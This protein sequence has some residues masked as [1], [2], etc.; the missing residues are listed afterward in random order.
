MS[1]A[2]GTRLGPYEIVAPLGEGGMGEVYKARDTRLGRTVAIKVLPDGD[3]ELNA[4]S[5]TERR[6]RVEREARFLSA[7]NH[8]HICVFHDVGSANGFDYLVMECLEGHTLAD[9][10]TRKGRL[11]VDEALDIAVQI[12]EALAAAH[13]QGIV[14]GD[15]KPENVMLTK[16]GAKVLDFG[17]ARLSEPPKPPA[18]TAPVLGTVTGTLPY[19]APE[20]LQ[21]AQVDARTDLFAFGAV[22]YE[23]LTGTRV[24]EGATPATIIA[25]ILEHEPRT[26]SAVVPSIPPA[27]DRLVTRCLAKNPDARWQTATDLAA[28]LR[29]LRDT[30]GGAGLVTTA[31]PGHRRAW[32]MVI[33]VAGALVMAAAGAG[34]MWLL[35]PPAAGAFLARPSLDVGPADQLSAGGVST[36]WLPTPGGSRTAIAW[37]PDGQALVFVGRRGGVQQ[38]YVRR[39]DA[40][41]ARALA[42]TEGAQAPAV[43]PDGL[44]VAFW[45]RRAIWKVPLGGG[46]AMMIAPD[47]NWPPRGQAWDDRGRLY[48]ARG[49]EGVIW[50]VPPDGGAP[51]AVATGGQSEVKHSLPW[52]LPGGQAL[53]YTVRTRQYSWGDEEVVA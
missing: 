44:W 5:R 50:Q 14:H 20:Q 45:A 52:P 6:H 4:A 8:P 23:M 9:R 31:Q 27:V 40:P 1:L 21:G 51:S 12:A 33:A 28:E 49:A 19:V 47:V 39:L 24:F 37:T 16:T 41:E 13:R 10:L 38:L 11:P 36:I 22:L 35:R 43:S 7:L 48:F 15:L 26:A 3:S 34:V 46:P 30:H 18:G 32:W 17:I 53:L 2:A 29:W 25:A 42:N